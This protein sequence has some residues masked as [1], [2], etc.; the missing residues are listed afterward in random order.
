[1][2][3]EQRSD[4]NF[5]Y[6]SMY[7]IFLCISVLIFLDRASCLYVVNVSVITEEKANMLACFTMIITRL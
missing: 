5:M 3:T 4:K 1:M 2:K 6:T 7:T